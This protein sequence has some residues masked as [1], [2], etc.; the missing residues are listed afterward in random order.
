MK[1][2]RIK[3][4]NFMS[5][6]NS[7]I[8]LSGYPAIIAIG[9]NG[10]GKSSLLID[11]LLVCI[12]GKG[13][14]GDIDGYV[15]G[16]KD[17]MTV[18]VDFSLDGS[19]YRVIRKRSKKT[20]R[21]SSSLEFLQLNPENNEV[22]QLTAGTIAETQSI[23]EKTIGI[24][25][26]L[27]TRT[28]ILPQGESEYFCSASP[29]QRMELFSTIWDLDRYEAMAQIA[30][31]TWT[32]LKSE[33][34][35][36]DGKI[37][38]MR[39]RIS[40][41]DNQKGELSKTKTELEKASLLV[42]VFEKKKGLLQQKIGSFENLVHDLQ[43]A[44]ELKA[45]AEQEI[46]R[47]SEQHTAILAKIE[48]YEKILKNR[49][50]VLA[51]V[52]E[53]K[54]KTV[55]LEEIERAT[56]TLDKHL[57][58]L[59]AEIDKIRHEH[60]VGIDGA[61]KAKAE[62]E[63]QI[64][65]AKTKEK[66]FHKTEAEIGRKEEE[67]KHLRL[68][69]DKL[70]GVS[71]H[72]DF[73]PQYVNE[74]CRFIKDAVEAKRRIPELEDQILTQKRQIASGMA[75][76]EAAMGQFQEKKTECLSQ[77]GDIRKKVELLIAEKEGKDKEINAKK[78]GHRTKI[79]RIRTE[80]TEIKRY[81]RL[82][83][84]IDLA[85][86]EL[87]ALKE[88][89]I[90]IEGRS[91]EHAAERDQA[92]VD[93]DRLTKK[94][95]EK[96]ILESEVQSIAKNLGEATGLKDSLTKRLGFIEAEI[97]Q[98]ETLKSQISESEKEIEKIGGEKAVYEILEGAFKQI[99]YMLVARGIGAVEKIANEI[100]SMIS[101]SGLTV[102]IETEKTT[103][104][105][106]KVKDEINLAI[107]DNE[108]SKIYP[109]LSGGERLRVAMALRLAISEVLAH[110]R[111]T[112]IDTLIADEPFGP[113]DVEGIEDMKEAMRELKKRFKFMGIIT[114]IDRAQDIFPTRLVFSKGPNGSQVEVQ[115]DYA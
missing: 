22:I 70:K 26:D 41:I 110:R 86:K 107:L 78:G 91:Y 90:E 112:R 98:G 72:P 109:L 81:T 30:R 23:I 79:D 32:G 80:L 101:S 64:L 108:G 47:A 40:E 74:G 82:V 48:R 18:E 44:K 84:E 58:G 6:H 43:K 77:I 69:A 114:H 105:T 95:D 8:N 93:I 31:D 54:E 38:S 49:D 33:I 24:D 21:G 67:L 29:S 111:G 25:F 89:A 97:S 100:L 56:E 85:G 15:T 103:K 53:E 45:R 35:T 13:R 42:S 7:E 104:T 5:H 88:E 51:K 106:K 37:A 71:C 87:P 16:S 113:L 2:D 115:E 10:T 20:A 34:A 36:L 61:E 52:E 55:F 65:D 1:I 94:Q 39:L 9:P 68:D 4:Q 102:K 96:A 3:A 66:E 73:D 17:L 11:A 60:Q 27:L 92:S 59:R 50:T 57:E 62:I 75:S 12:F 83:P 19:K 99:P 28:S 46:K 63:A 14:S 76:I